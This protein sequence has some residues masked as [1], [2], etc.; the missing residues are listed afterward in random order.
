M[1]Q[2]LEEIGS[3]EKNEVFQEVPYEGQPLIGTIWVL[4]VKDGTRCQAKLVAEG[5]QDADSDSIV[6]FS[7]TSGLD[8]IFLDKP[9]PCTLLLQTRR[10]IRR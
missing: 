1:T 7:P 6:K 10:F 2:K 9:Y 4:T 8:V 3:W 5:F